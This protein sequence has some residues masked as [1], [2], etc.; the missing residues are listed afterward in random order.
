MW[1]HLVSGSPMQALS[2]DDPIRLLAHNLDFW[3]PATDGVL[4]DILGAS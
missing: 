2:R 3:V 4:T 1:R